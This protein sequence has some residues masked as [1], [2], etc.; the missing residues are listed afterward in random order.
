MYENTELL[1]VNK[2]NK[3]DSLY[4]HSQFIIVVVVFELYRLFVSNCIAL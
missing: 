4:K 2:I 1:E 3:L